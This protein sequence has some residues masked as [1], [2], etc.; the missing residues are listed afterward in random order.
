MKQNPASLKVAPGTKPVRGIG[1]TNTRS[2][3]PACA[4]LQLEPDAGPPGSPAPHTAPVI[5]AAVDFRPDSLRA[6]D[7]A[8]A[9]A[10]SLEASILLVH[11][12]EAVYS[13]G[14]VN[15]M[16]R[17]KVK[18]EARRRALK[19]AEDL[20]QYR[21]AQGV[22]VTCLVR[23]GWPPFEI[24]QIAQRLQVDV[25]VLGRRP[26]SWL[27]RWLMGGVSDDILDFATCPVVVI[28]RHARG[29]RRGGWRRD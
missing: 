8:F 11:V 1:Q 9:L 17:Q 24:L 22:P 6:L 20:A 26:R 28:N 15:W 7:H 13:D 3:D 2:E 29:F 10:R 23:D 21:A 14:L 5:L 16:T 19:Q 18:A 27:R 12:L 25:I 4:R